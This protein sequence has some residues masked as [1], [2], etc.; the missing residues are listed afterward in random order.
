MI[1]SISFAL[2]IPSAMSVIQCCRSH[3]HLAPAKRTP[4]FLG[5]F[6]T[7]PPQNYRVPQLI[8]ILGCFAF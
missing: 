2:F 5:G 6:Q 8:H 3:S 7:Y 4:A 1:E